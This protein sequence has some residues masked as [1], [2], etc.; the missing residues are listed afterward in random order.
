MLPGDYTR[1]HDAA[2]ADRQRC[3]RWTERYVMP[4]GGLPMLSHADSLLETG[5]DG[6]CLNLLTAPAEAA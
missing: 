4:A 3:L 6:R 1:C 5:A 2:C